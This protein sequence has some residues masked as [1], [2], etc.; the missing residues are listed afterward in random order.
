MIVQGRKTFRIVILPKTCTP[1]DDHNSRK[2][3]QGADA[4]TLTTSAAKAVRRQQRCSRQMGGRVRLQHR[5]DH[6]ETRKVAQ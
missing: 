6:V 2:S 5:S 4:E 1:T 3:G